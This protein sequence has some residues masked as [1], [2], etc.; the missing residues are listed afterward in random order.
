MQRKICAL[1]VVSL[2]LI[3]QG[4]CSAAYTYSDTFT[5]PDSGVGGSLGTTED[6]NHLNWIYDP[7]RDD[8]QIA[9]GKLW[10][11]PDLTPGGAQLSG[12]YP[13]FE[14]E[15]DVQALHGPYDGW[16]GILA[17]LTSKPMEE[18][19]NGFAV[20]FDSTNNRALL[21]S[22]PTGH[23]GGYNLPSGTWYDLERH[24]HIKVSKNL[25][26]SIHHQAW[27]D[28]IP[29]WDVD[30]F[31]QGDGNKL[32]FGTRHLSLTYDN[33]Q[34]VPEPASILGLLSG[35]AGFGLMSLRRKR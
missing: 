21:F 11:A 12:S 34:L 1:G 23:L 18:N 14:L 17:Y 30:N 35:V 10:A 27:L 6:S 28:G 2:L 15:V 16:Y 7:G 24:L 33:L 32:G 4:V 13:V 26:G 25:N 9:N 20:Q 22:G 5:R 3:L 31:Y 19:G 8:M 29:M